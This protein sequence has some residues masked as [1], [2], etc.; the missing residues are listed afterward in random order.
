MRE[1][2]KIRNNLAL[3]IEQEMFETKNN[4]YSFN[5]PYN[6]SSACNQKK[7]AQANIYL[8]KPLHKK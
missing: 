8:L 1:I 2:L 6:I 4:P 3:P 5:N 7:K